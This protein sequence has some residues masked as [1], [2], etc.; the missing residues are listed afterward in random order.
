MYPYSD[1]DHNPNR[2]KEAYCEQ[3]KPKGE[4]YL[5]MCNTSSSFFFFF[6]NQF[7][8][9]PVNRHTIDKITEYFFRLILL[10]FYRKKKIF[11]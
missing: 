6:N 4:T 2:E 7:K 11:R 5:D 9:L 10:L 8:H 1:S 3:D